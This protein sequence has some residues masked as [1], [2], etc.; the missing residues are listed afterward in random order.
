MVVLARDHRLERADRVVE[1]DELAGDPGEYLG[2]VERLRQEAL[3]L[4]GPGNDQFVLFGK[5][6]HAE[7][8]D[9]VLQALVALQS[10]LDGARGFVM[11]LPD[12]P[13]LEHPAGR[14]ERVDRGI[15]AELGN[16]AV[17]RR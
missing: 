15:N 4:A 5:L 17:E 8:G 14:I 6:I 2:D 13:G 3:D 1:L 11:L 7:D 10:R 9:D 16:R 12:R